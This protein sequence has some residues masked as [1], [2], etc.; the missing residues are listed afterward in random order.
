MFRWTIPIVVAM[1]AVV[2]TA[3]SDEAFAR[4]GVYR[5]AARLP[6]GLP[7]PH[8][9]FRTTISWAA[10]YSNRWSYAPPIYAYQTPDVVFTPGYV[11]V[12]YIP[13]LLPGYYGPAYPYYQDAYYGGSSAGYWDLL[14][15][16]CG[17][18]GYC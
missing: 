18:Y 3:G 7:R 11:A 8:Y 16:A 13:P 12:P 2:T 9:N 4:R 10:P 15:Y 5:A 17:V 6:A 14:P 1:A